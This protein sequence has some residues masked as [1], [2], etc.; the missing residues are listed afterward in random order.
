VVRKLTDDVC[1]TTT[2]ESRGKHQEVDNGVKRDGLT[3]GDADRM[4]RPI[5]SA[6]RAGIAA[7]R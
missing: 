2:N 5:S 4:R 7:D 6:A 1:P 3:R